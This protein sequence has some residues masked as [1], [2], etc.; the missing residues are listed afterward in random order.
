[1]GSHGLTLAVWWMECQVQKKRPWAS[2]LLMP[3]D[4]EKLSHLINLF[5]E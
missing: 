1:M 3:G 5:K 2:F 4:A